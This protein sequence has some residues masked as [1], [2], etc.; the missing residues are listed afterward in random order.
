MCFYFVIL[1]IY[2]TAN[3]LNNKFACVDLDVK[4][5][6]LFHRPNEKKDAPTH[7]NVHIGAAAAIN[8][9]IESG[10]SFI[11]L[12]PCIFRW[13]SSAVRFEQR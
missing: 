3:S 6:V 5:L 11:A 7:V 13:R 2:E 1:I 10:F 12:S 9:K 8:T 4:T